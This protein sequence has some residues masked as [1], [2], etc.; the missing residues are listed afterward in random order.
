[1]RAIASL[2]VVFACVSA[3]LG[4]HPP[5]AIARDGAAT[6]AATCQG[7]TSDAARGGCLSAEADARL[8]QMH[9][10]LDRLESLDAGASVGSRVSLKP[11]LLQAESEWE[12]WIADECR[13]EGDILRGSAGGV[14]EPACRLRLITER[15]QTLQTMAQNGGAGLA[16][17]M[18]SNEGCAQPSDRAQLECLNQQVAAADP[19]LNALYQSVL[20]ALPVNDPNDQRGNRAQLVKAQAD[21]RAFAEANCQYVGA[22]EGGSNLWIT[23]FATRCLLD[24]TR[25]RILFFEREAAGKGGS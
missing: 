14:A 23:N 10:A 15:T 22:S 1:M 25:R 11:S 5:Q 12:R 20:E 21:W 24:E 19:Q 18:A 9:Q 17:S 2:A 4:A 3:L 13:L 8:L 16:G 7:L 6:A